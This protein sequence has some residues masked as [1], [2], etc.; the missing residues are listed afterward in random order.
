MIFKIQKGEVIAEKLQ[1]M[2]DFAVN[3]NHKSRLIDDYYEDGLDNVVRMTAIYHIP[4]NSYNEDL[5]Y[6]NVAKEDLIAILNQDTNTG[7]FQLYTYP[8]NPLGDIIS[9]PK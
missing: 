5:T 7:D 9:S 6:K 3:Y 2:I 1:S 4:Y 8:D